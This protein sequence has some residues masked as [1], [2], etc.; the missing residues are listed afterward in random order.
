VRRLLAILAAVGMV[1]AAVLLRG[2]IDDD[3]ASA[4]GGE[5]SVVLCATDLADACRTLDPAVEVRIQDP[6]DTV[7]ALAEGTLAGVDAWITSTAWLEVAESRAPDAIGDARAIASSRGTVASAP[8]RSDAIRELCGDQDVWRCLGDATGEAWDDLVAGAPAGWGDLKVGMPDADLATGLPVIASAA[9]GFFGRADFVASDPAF[10]AEF[11]SWLADLT[12][13]S[14]PG[15]PDPALTMATR[16]G[17]Y[18]AAGSLRALAAAVQGRGIEEIAPASDVAATVATVELR[19]GDGL[20]GTDEVRDALVDAGWAS[21]S[22]ADLAPTLKP[23]VMA[24]LHTLWRDV[25]S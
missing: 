23:G 16:A 21:A 24:A 7:A 17:A 13:P 15:D 22:E 18:S 4:G 8:D 1:V 3:D 25:T 14:G 2:A 19:G 9:A 20:P 10:D 12:G 6:A 11:A 5:A